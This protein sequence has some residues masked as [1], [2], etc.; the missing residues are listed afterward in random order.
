MDSASES[1]EDEQ[2]VPCDV[3]L[4]SGN[5][6]R[7][8][9]E[10]EIKKPPAPPQ[11][12]GQGPRKSTC[13]TCK[14]ELKKAPPKRK[15]PA[16]Q[17]LQ[18]VRHIPLPGNLQ[19]EGKAE[20]FY[21]KMLEEK[22]KV[23]KLTEEV[24]VWKKKVMTIE[25]AT[26]TE[27][28]QEGTLERI[29]NSD[30]N[31]QK[32]NAL[33]KEIALLTGTVK[34]LKD[35]NKNKAKELT[36]LQSS[37]PSTAKGRSRKILSDLKKSD[38]TVNMLR[39][40]LTTISTMNATSPSEGAVSFSRV[41]DLKQRN[42]DL[43]SKL[44]ASNEELTRTKETAADRHVHVLM[45]EWALSATLKKRHFLD[46]Q[47]V[48]LNEMLEGERGRLERAKEES[49]NTIKHLEDAVKR[50]HDRVVSLSGQL[51]QLQ[52]HA[53]GKGTEEWA[54]MVK[55]Y[56]DGL[57]KKDEAI[58]SLEGKLLEEERRYRDHEARVKDSDAQ[59][60][61]KT[62]ALFKEDIVTRDATISRLEKELENLTK[63]L[64][65][66]NSQ[67]E[68]TMRAASAA[69]SEQDHASK[70]QEATFGKQ[71]EKYK[72][73]VN[74]LKEDLQKERQ[75]TQR[76]KALQASQDAKIEKLRTEREKT[77]LSTGRMI[78]EEDEM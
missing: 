59:V 49:Q 63:Q 2:P 12:Q 46:K 68:A 65:G 7:K 45:A 1:S 42:L 9:L 38:D 50:E 5:Q 48:D 77:R 13:P 21:V 16:G 29:M 11:G 34:S 72:N 53:K 30:S 14:Q 37:S 20:E 60:R 56:E 66:T 69:M 76:L 25:K 26:K 36:D 57:V 24:R 15:G 32:V 64:K 6:F 39:T 70:K 55:S 10:K 54:Q 19:E 27:K 18:A 41:E 74:T 43:K 22:E 3:Q 61:K 17:A 62:S 33:L 40:Q 4:L 31:T 67:K 52:Y 75:E 8:M 47:A 58:T 71:T 51:Q 28:K 44:K 73:K 23:K 78:Q 35:D